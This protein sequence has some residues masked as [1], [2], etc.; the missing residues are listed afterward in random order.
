MKNISKSI[1]MIEVQD[2]DNLVSETYKRPYN[3]QQ[4]DDCQGRGTFELN[5]P[6]EDDNEEYMNDSVP[7]KVNGEEMGVK[8]KVWLERD[9]NLNVFNHDYENELY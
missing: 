8:F 1:K 4:Q 7:E 3:F 6:S 2:W 5:I 9:P